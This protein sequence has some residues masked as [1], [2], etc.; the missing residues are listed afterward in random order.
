MSQVIKI[1]LK[2]HRYEEEADNYDYNP[3]EE[4]HQPCVEIYL[5]II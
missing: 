5:N 3:N 4:G 2:M 1:E